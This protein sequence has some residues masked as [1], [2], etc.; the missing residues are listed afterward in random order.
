[1]KRWRWSS[2]VNCTGWLSLVQAFTGLYRDDRIMIYNKDQPPTNMMSSHMKMDY[3]RMVHSWVIMLQQLRSVHQWTMN[4]ICSM[5]FIKCQTF[6]SS[7]LWHSL[8]H[9]NI[10]EH[11]WSHK[12]RAIIW[13]PIQNSP[14]SHSNHSRVKT[15]QDVHWNLWIY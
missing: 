3:Q 7:S 10:S 5:P 2:S 1:M 4:N 8:Y 12:K 13:K 6:P 15:T 11:T 14:N 9:K